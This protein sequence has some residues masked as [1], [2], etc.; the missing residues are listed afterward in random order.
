MTTADRRHGSYSSLRR[1]FFPPRTP[2]LLGSVQLRSYANGR[3][4]MLLAAIVT[5][6]LIW[7]VLRDSPHIRH[8]VLRVF[9][10]VNISLL[11]LDVAATFAVLRKPNRARFAVQTGCLVIEA[12]TIVIWVQVTGTLSSYFLVAGLLL[13]LVYRAILGYWSG[14]VMA[15]GMAALHLGACVLEELHVLRPAA[16]F[17]SDPG[18]LY[19]FSAYRVAAMLSIEFLYVFTFLGANYIVGALRAKEEALQEA[20]ADLVRAVDQAR[21]GHLSG[22]VLGGAYELRE[23]LGCGGMGEVYAATSLSDGRPVAV[24]VLGLEAYASPQIRERF[25]RE[26]DILARLPAAHVA[27]VHQFGIDEEARQFIVMDLLRGEDLGA[28][29]RRRGAVPLDEV[30]GLADRI[31]AALHSAHQLGIVHRDLKPENVFLLG[32][33]GADRELR[34]L[35]FGVA[36]LAQKD[37][38]PGLTQQF[39]VLGSPGYL[40]PEQARGTLAEI[41]PQTDVFAFGAILYLALSGR[42]AFPARAPAEAIYQALHLEPPPVRSLR[43]ELPADVEDVLALALA[44]RATDRYPRALLLVEHLRL[45]AATNLPAE[46][47]QRAAQVRAARGAAVAVERGN[48]LV[49]SANL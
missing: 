41:G 36:H 29:L 1:W 5:D 46:V 38:Q 26:A 9:A 35:D 17:V 45:A 8:H 23:I 37:D 16:L 43:P 47:R 44:K 4:L 31:A 12:F 30:L 39:A 33:G 42:P 2:E 15:I 20:R 21:H 10:T 34:L 25:R 40:S 22:R 19:A 7:W 18:A 48:T 27:A 32:D 6:V 3:L 11:A 28:H 49:A 14:L 24:K 13:I